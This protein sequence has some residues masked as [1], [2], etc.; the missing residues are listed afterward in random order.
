MVRINLMPAHI[1]IYMGK[2]DF[3]NNNNLSLR[4]ATI[5]TKTGNNKCW[6]RSG[7]TGTLVC[8]LLAGM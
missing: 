4:M 1:L 6:Q 2:D 5:K 7:E 8:I 3:R